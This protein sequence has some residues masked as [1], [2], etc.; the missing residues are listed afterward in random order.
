MTWLAQQ[1]GV[2]RQ[3]T[4]DVAHGNRTCNRDTAERMSAALG[5][6]LFLVFDLLE[7]NE[8]VLGRIA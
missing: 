3:Y 5:V 8:P 1:L 7:S 4:S 2:S 6:P